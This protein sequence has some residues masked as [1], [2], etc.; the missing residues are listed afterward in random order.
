MCSIRMPG[1]SSTANRGDGGAHRC[2]SGALRGRVDQQAA[3]DLLVDV[4][5]LQGAG[6]RPGAVAAAGTARHGA[7]ARGPADMGRELPGLQRQKGLVSVEP[8]EEPGGPLHGGPPDRRTGSAVRCAENSSRP[9]FRTMPPSIPPGS[10]NGS[11]RQTVPTSCGWRTLPILRPGWAW[12][13]WHSSS[14]CLRPARRRLPEPI[15]NIP[16]A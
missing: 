5:R 7:V 6:S 4:L 15:G 12:S 13:S 3:A 10:C 14:W 1:R 16:P 8:R 2:P 11:F 9:A